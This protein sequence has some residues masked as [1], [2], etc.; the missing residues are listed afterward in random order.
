MSFN[1]SLQHQLNTGVPL[2]SYTSYSFSLYVV[3]VEYTRKTLGFASC[4]AKKMR[5]NSL[6]HLCVTNVRNLFVASCR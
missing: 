2:W 3:F 1:I 6:R 4:L 5:E